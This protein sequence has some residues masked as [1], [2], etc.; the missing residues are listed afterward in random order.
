MRRQGVRTIAFGGRPQYGPMQAIGG[1]RGAQ[2]LAYGGIYS[3]IDIAHG[4][5]RDSLRNGSTALMTTDQWAEFNKSL[6]VHSNEFPFIF[7]G[8]INLRNEYAPEDD[9]TPQQFTYQAADCRL[10]YTADNWFSQEAIWRSAAQGLFQ[11]GNRCVLGSTS[12]D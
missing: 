7:G 4:L 10:F 1:T 6:P 8:G 12:S 2:N 9:V 5:I 3:Y 11:G